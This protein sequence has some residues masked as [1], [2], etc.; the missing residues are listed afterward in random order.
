MIDMKKLWDYLDVQA[1]N[2]PV[3]KSYQNSSVNI[4]CNDCFKVSGCELEMG[5]YSDW[6][7]YF[8]SAIDG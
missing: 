2:I 8:C 3:P 1:L 4:F 7:D 5:D 6:F